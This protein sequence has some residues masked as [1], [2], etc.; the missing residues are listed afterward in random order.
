M[1][2]DESHFNVSVGCG[3]ECYTVSPVVVMNVTPHRQ[4][5]CGDKCYMV[6]TVMLM[7][8]IFFPNTRLQPNRLPSSM[9]Q[10]ERNHYKEGA[11]MTIRL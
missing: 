2:S 3:D 11:M 9:Q 6:R 4:S 10:K 7:D 1:G 5:G 8:A